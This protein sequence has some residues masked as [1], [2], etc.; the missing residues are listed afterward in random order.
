MTLFGPR[1]DNSNPKIAITKQDFQL[2]ARDRG[3]SL[4]ASPGTITFLG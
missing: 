4:T 1:T 3:S 2:L